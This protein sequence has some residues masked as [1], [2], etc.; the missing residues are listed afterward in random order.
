MPH[1]LHQHS[2]DASKRSITINLGVLDANPS[3]TAGAIGIYEKLQKNISSTQDKPYTFIVYG[4][5]LSCER[6]NDAHR[7]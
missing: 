5:G 1:I 2:N 7:A 6:G 4:D 3:S